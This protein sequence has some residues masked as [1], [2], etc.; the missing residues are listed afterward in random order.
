MFKN[1]TAEQLVAKFSSPLYI[2]DE[3]IL[4]DNCQK[5]KMFSNNNNLDIHYA[6]KANSNIALLKIIRSQ[7]LKV[8]TITI[9][10]LKLAQLAGFSKQDIFFSS[11]N[12]S[13]QDIQWLIK[14]DIYICLDSISQLE[15]YF[16]LG[17]TK[18]CCI[19]I[20]PKIGDGH[21][22][23]VITAG[24]VKFGIDLD[25]ID[26][27]FRLA[28]KYQKKINGLN[29]HIGSLFLET[30]YFHKA[31]IELLAL[32]EKYPSITYLDFGGGFGIPYREEEK[33]FPIEQY[34]KKFKQTL[35][36]WANKQTKK[37]DFGIQPGR[38]IVASAG[39]CIA[40]VQSIKTN[41]NI[42][43][44]GTDLGFNFLLRPEFY[45]AYHKITNCSKNLKKTQKFTIV[46][47]VCESGD[48]LGK[49]RKLPFDTEVGDFL[50]IHDTGGYGYAMASNYNSMLRPAEILINLEGEAVLIRKKETLA[51]LVS[52]QCF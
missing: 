17:G 30:T 39:C 46:G 5:I 16:Q 1:Y 3:K 50:K 7:G 45:N 9:P 24:K 10:E 41:R 42:N 31:V 29:I 32:A 21:H 20:N 23:R 25:Q 22:P 19:R 44:L 43:F 35:K 8:E 48:V 27:A 13:K 47:N 28:D 26:L 15:S 34:S 37:I 40:Q 52:G 12:I 4:V 36:E 6:T 2:Y 49:D 18:D 33:N 11:N 38:Y 14:Q 51:N